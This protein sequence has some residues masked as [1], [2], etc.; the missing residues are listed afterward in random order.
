MRKNQTVIHLPNLWLWPYA[1]KAPF[2]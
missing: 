1:H 2:S